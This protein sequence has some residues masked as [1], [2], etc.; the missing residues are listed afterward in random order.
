MDY[1]G[2]EGFNCFPSERKKIN[3]SK[4]TI[5]ELHHDLNIFYEKIK[6]LWKII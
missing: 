3:N 2:Y 5:E 4:R 1:D 6:I